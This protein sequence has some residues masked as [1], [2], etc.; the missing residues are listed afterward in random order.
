MSV[1]AGTL[2]ST[3][4]QERRRVDRR[5]SRHF[6]VRERRSGF[7]RRRRVRVR[8]L[9]YMW[10]DCLVY[11]RDNASALIVALLLTNVF[12]VL[13][14]VLTV[15]ALQIGAR[16]ENPF[17]GHLL[18][19]SPVLAGAVKVGVIAGFT[20]V[21]WRLRR[22]RLMLAVALLAAAIYFVVILYH[23]YGLVSMS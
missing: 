4:V 18:D 7:D 8:I 21:I 19:V 16:E 2:E 15:H 9:G 14:F 11:L 22:Y 10:D 1:E 6:V 5:V 13:D 12:S 3:A 20:L 17:M 23:C